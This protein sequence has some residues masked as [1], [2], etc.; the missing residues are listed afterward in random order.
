MIEIKKSNNKLHLSVSTEL[1]REDVMQLLKDL[2]QWLVDT[3]EYP[4]FKGI[5]EEKIKEAWTDNKHV[6]FNLPMQ[7]A[8]SGYTKEYMD[9]YLQAQSK[10]MLEESM[11]EYIASIKGTQHI[12]KELETIELDPLNREVEVTI[13]KLKEN[14]RN[15]SGKTK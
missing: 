9:A 11:K 3:A 4:K 10:R 15:K 7:S 12:K 14:G 2:N 8:P 5:S 1:D 6:Q 13:T